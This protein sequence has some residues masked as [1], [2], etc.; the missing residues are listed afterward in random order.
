[1][2]YPETNCDHCKFRLYENP[3][4][5]CRAFPDGIPE[6]FALGDEIH[7]KVIPDQ[8]AEFIYTPE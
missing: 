6:K 3:G 7:D 1:M 5:F 8:V 4:Q 2:I